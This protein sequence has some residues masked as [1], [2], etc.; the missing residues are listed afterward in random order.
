MR[1]SEKIYDS[2]KNII[3]TNSDMCF[4]N[5][6]SYNVVNLDSTITGITADSPKVFILD[7]ETEIPLDIT[8][9]DNLEFLSSE[10]SFNYNILPYDKTLGEF[11]SSGMYVSTPVQYTEVNHETSVNSVDLF[12]EG[13]YLMKLSYQY[14]SCTQIA[15]VLGKQYIASTYSSA[16]PF[17]HL[18]TNHD[19][20]F[21][22]LYKADEPRLDVGVTSGGGTTG[23]DI[24]NTN[25][26]I[27]QPMPVETGVRTYPL[28]LTSEGDFLIS[29]NGSVLTKDA[30][31]TIS[32]GLVTFLGDVF[33]SDIVNYIFIGRSN[34]SSLKT[35]SAIIDDYIVSGTTGNQGDNKI[36]FNTDS[37]KYELYTDYR[38]TNPDGVVV[39]L[40]GTVL[41]TN[42]D[43]Y[44]SSSNS[45]RI[46][47]NGAIYPGDILSIIYDSGENLNRSVTD[48]FIDL[49]WYVIKPI[50]TTEGEFVVEF[51]KSETFTII[52]QTEIVPYELNKLQYTHR[53]PMNYPYGTV[54]HY[55]IR[56]IKRYTTISNTVLETM[57]TSDSIR[58]EV[59]TNISNNY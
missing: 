32:N 29:L 14:L 2:H 12:G 17:K 8:F 57:S 11:N 38:I 49:S 20:Y 56:N 15:K 41:S 40:Q 39:T 26:F 42:V 3:R 18:D 28:N 46:I 21:I 22:V 6:P 31:F 7:E 54:L 1:Y 43:F 13:E 10:V 36:Y 55:R 58:I 24:N 53:V 37:Q 23:G 59:K 30:D 19:K 48:G 33:T 9:V 47:F 34:T 35:E 45:K 5:Y 51:S 25:A 27:V 4:F 52:E 16:L 50:T 44:V